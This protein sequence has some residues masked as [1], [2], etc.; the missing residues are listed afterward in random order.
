MSHGPL[1]INNRE[2]NELCEYILYVLCIPKF[3]NSEVS[4]CQHLKNRN[5]IQ[6]DKIPKFQVLE[7]KFKDQKL[8]Y[9]YVSQFSKVQML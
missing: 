7:N 9:T 3:Q 4:K 8:G 6:N 5:F 1:T 2:I